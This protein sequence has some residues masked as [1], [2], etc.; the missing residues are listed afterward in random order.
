MSQWIGAARSNYFHVTDVEEFTEWAEAH[1]LEVLTRKAKDGSDL[2]ALFS[3]ENGWSLLA[4]EEEEEAGIED[5]DIVEEICKRLELPNEVVLLVVAGF[6]KC[7]YVSG[8]ST[9]FTKEF[10]QTVSVST[11]DIYDKAAE[12]FGVPV[13]DIYEMDT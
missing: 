7:W 2:V 6:E 11:Y 9:A 4:T 1:D 8:T 5:P 3:G 13:D 12:A 10:P